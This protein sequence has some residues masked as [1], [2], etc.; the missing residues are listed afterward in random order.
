M[1]AFLPQVAAVVGL[2][3]VQLLAGRLRGRSRLWLSAGAGVSVAFVFLHLLPELDH[4]TEDVEDALGHLV[5]LGDRPVLVLA[6]AGLVTFYGLERLGRV[7]QRPHG[8]GVAERRVALVSIGAF[9]LYYALI[10]YLVGIEPDLTSL[11]LFAAAMGVH[12]LAVDYGLRVHHADT[13]DRVGRWVLAAAVVSGWGV[14][15]LAT[16]PDPA[17]AVMLSVLAGAVIL[18]S[19]KEE[20][21]PNREGRFTAFA[22]GAALYALLLA[23]L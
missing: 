14:A 17:V 15:R 10:G 7:S 19:L 2:A 3:A 11:G 9:A 23:A 16:L 22:G 5:P 21:P 1:P 8:G 13:Y 6:L 18:I 12:F 4:V 20:L